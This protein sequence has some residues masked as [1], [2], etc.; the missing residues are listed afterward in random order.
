MIGGCGG[1]IRGGGGEG[2]GGAG[3]GGKGG[4]LGGGGG[5]GDGG[6]EGGAAAVLITAIMLNSP[7]PMAL[8]ARTE[9]VCCLPGVRP[10]ALYWP[11]TSPG[12]T[13]TPVTV[14]ELTATS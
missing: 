13:A 10:L 1:G 14:W 11:K 12:C 7:A 3:G 6:I 8:T 9:K 4:G 2:G 5:A